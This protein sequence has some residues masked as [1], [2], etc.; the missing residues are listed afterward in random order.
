MPDELASIPTEFWANL[1]EMAPYLLFGFAVA[2]VLSVLIRPETVE[3]HLGGRG[4]W[5]VVKAAAFG[6]PLPLCSCGVIPVSASLRKHGASR[7]ATTAFLLSTPQTGV[8]SILV[9]LSLLGPVFAIFRPI[10]ALATGVFGGALVAWLEH[11]R[12][13]RMDPDSCQDACGSGE[14]RG[15]W[16]VRILS[17]GFVTL[18]RDIGKS[19]LV[20]L[21]LAGV[22]AVVVPKDLATL[23]GSGFVGMVV[24]M[25]LGIPIYVCATASVPIAA[26][27]IAKGVSPGAALAFLITGP[28][29]NAAT[30]AV[31]WKTMG[32]RTALIYL[33]SVAI[34]ALGCG[35]LLDLIYASTVTAAHHH[36]VHEL[37]PHGA[38]LASAIALLGVLGV[39]LLWRPK[40]EGTEPMTDQ[41]PETVELSVQ[42]MTCSHCVGA[43]TRALRECRGVAAAEVDL[44]SGRAVVKG[45]GLDAAALRQAVEALGYTVAQP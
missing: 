13:A 39:A 8:D 3:R 16:L 32:R 40:K 37:L 27:L 22:I 23:Y 12:G 33:A 20:G 34:A 7:G 43:V 15:N 2:G 41:A 1:L 10:A 26:A 19:L 17:Y 9:T 42:G 35:A 31:V 36:H 14:E 45:Q 29:T 25:A 21:A 6:V 5:P 38:K 24:M 44:K 4:L 11:E 18:P 30:V 28:A